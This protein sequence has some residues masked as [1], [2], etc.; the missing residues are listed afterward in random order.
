[1][2]SS[3]PGFTSWAH[4]VRPFPPGHWWSS[5]HQSPTT[6][7]VSHHCN[8]ALP[9]LLL[10]HVH[11]SPSSAIR[12]SSLIS[13]DHCPSASPW[14]MILYLF[15][16]KLR[17]SFLNSTYFQKFAITFPPQLAR[18]VFSTYQSQVFAG[19]LRQSWEMDCCLSFHVLISSVCL[20]AWQENTLR[21]KWFGVYTW[22]IGWVHV[23]L[24]VIFIIL[25][26]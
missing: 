3:M 11:G 25:T 26:L 8:T 2:S 15:P 4:A 17:F 7:G 22:L 12:L 5:D 23:L 9:F 14:L 1:M 24:L 20:I 13:Q 6:N 21:F 16:P 10:P 18:N 19:H